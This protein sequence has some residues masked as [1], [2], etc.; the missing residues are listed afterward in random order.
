MGCCNS[1]SKSDKL[2]DLYIN[3][4]NLPKMNLEEVKESLDAKLNSS[5]YLV[6]LQKIL[7]NNESSLM[8]VK[9]PRQKISAEFF[10]QIIKE[11]YL[12]SDDSKDRQGLIAYQ[13]NFLL[14]VFNLSGSSKEKLL[15]YLFPLMRKGEDGLEDFLDLLRKSTS[16][17]ITFQKFKRMMEKYYTSQIIFPLEALSAES[18]D[19]KIK[20]ESA[21]LLENIA[22]KTNISEFVNKLLDGLYRK[23]CVAGGV[24]DFFLEDRE[25]LS[26]FAPNR[27]IVLSFSYIRVSFYKMFS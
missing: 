8:S 10:S 26:V 23:L 7:K 22:T 1:I 27:D 13:Q 3:Q 16:E 15:L 19:S 4:S 20:D 5:T 17:E 11:F 25:I 18:K 9:S 12:N 21:Y 14:R 2:I 6:E 24:E